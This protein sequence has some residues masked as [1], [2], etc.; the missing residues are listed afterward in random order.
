MVMPKSG[1]GP[2]NTN[3][4]QRNKSKS[5]RLS[6][7]QCSSKISKS[8]NLMKR[9]TNWNLLSINKSRFSV[10]ELWLNIFLSKILNKSESI[11]K[12]SRNNYKILKI[13]ILLGIMKPKANKFRNL[14]ARSKLLPKPNKQK[15][16]ITLENSKNWRNMQLMPLIISTP[17]IGIQEQLPKFMRKSKKFMIGLQKLSKNL[18]K[19][20]LVN[21]HW[22]HNNQ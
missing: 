22:F 18:S 10:T 12:D 6:R 15:S 11:L 13:S 8:S 2:P 17:N 7:D 4:F 20:K 5:L 3:H 14:P 21:Y 9:R 19:L 1:S 16:K